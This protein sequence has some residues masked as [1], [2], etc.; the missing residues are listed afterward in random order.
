[1]KTAVP[2]EGGVMKGTGHRLGLN[3]TRQ[4]FLERGVALS[5][6]VSPGGDDSHREFLAAAR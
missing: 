5:V 4:G 1:M 3:F 6:N 2:G